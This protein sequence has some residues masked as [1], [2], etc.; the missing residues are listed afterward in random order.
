MSYEHAPS[1]E[2]LPKIGEKMFSNMVQIRLAQVSYEVLHGEKPDMSKP[3][4]R[5]VVGME[6]AALYAGSFGRYLKNHPQEAFDI[7]DEDAL[8]RL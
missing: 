3:E 6:W 8:F 7:S 5:N 2:S 1:S 4:V